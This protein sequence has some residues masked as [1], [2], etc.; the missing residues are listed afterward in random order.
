M[1]PFHG[2][3]VHGRDALRQ[4]W[5]LD[6]G[7]HVAQQYT[8]LQWYALCYAMLALDLGRRPMLPTLVSRFYRHKW[9]KWKGAASSESMR[10]LAKRPNRRVSEQHSPVQLQH[11]HHS[12]DQDVLSPVHGWRK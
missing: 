2:L 10:E 11:R 6:R 5:R 7:L 12:R 9:S 1:L 3:C 8:A 4:T